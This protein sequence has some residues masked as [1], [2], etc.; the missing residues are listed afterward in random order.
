MTSPKSPTRF[1][2]GKPGAA[3]R[4]FIESDDRALVDAQLQPGEVA[5]QVAASASSIV[6]AANGGTAAARVAV[7]LPDLT[8][9]AQM[10]VNVTVPAGA[11]WSANSKA[12]IT[13]GVAGSYPMAMSGGWVGRATITVLSAADYEAWLLGRIDDE[14]ERR[15]M[16]VLS[17]GGAKKY[18]YARKDSEA[19]DAK[20]LIVSVLNALSL[21]DRQ[22]RFPFAQAEA[23]LTG[24]PIT[25]VLA[26]FAASRTEV[27]RIESVAQK[28][29]RAIK[30][31][32]SSATKLAAFNA[33]A[34]F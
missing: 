14:R 3:A 21:V 4:G 12:Y 29:K 6:I 8:T 9:A 15:Q 27:A 10:P 24:D 2:L 30:A 19:A 33:V 25:T 34:W 13:I 22:K 31:A 28:A 23:T 20:T 18:V 26:R 11:S 17:A 1:A 32:T 7:P 5:V 16:L